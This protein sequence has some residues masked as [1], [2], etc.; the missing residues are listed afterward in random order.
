MVD[1]EQALATSVV[2]VAELDA[3][4]RDGE[5]RQRLDAFVAAFDVLVL[6]R[7]PAQPAAAPAAPSPLPRPL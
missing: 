1:T 5:E 6:D 2:T 7:E 4:V 3:G